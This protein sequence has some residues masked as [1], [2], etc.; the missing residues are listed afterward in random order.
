MLAQINLSCW[1]QIAVLMGANTRADW[2]TLNASEFHLSS[3]NFLRRLF[4]KKVPKYILRLCDNR[5]NVRALCPRSRC[6]FVCSDAWVDYFDMYFQVII[7][8]PYQHFHFSNNEYGVQRTTI[9]R[10]KRWMFC[11]ISHSHRQ[12]NTHFLGPLL[13]HWYISHSW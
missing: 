8:N 4:K 3:F 7:L 5:L 9:Q 6:Q 10:N 13:I 11:N 2:K 1:P 12:C